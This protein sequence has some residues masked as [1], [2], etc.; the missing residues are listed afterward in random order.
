MSFGARHFA[1]ESR[2]QDVAEH[3]SRGTTVQHRCHR[4]LAQIAAEIVGVIMTVQANDWSWGPVAMSTA[5][6]AMNTQKRLDTWRHVEP[7][8]RPHTP[9]ISC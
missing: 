2:K 5:E 6:T 1:L 7:L 9:N 3:G 4:E 8:D